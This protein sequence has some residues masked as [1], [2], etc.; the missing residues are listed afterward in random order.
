MNLGDTKLGRFESV[1]NEYSPN[2]LDRVPRCAS[3]SHSSFFSGCD[4]WYVHELSWLDLNGFPLRGVATL[5]IP[6][7]S[8]FMVE[9]KSAKLYFNSFRFFVVGSQVAL[10][11]LIIKDFSSLLGCPIGCKISDFRHNI[12]TPDCDSI[13]SCLDHDPIDNISYDIDSCRKYLKIDEA[14]QFCSLRVHTNLFLT[15][16]PVTSQPDFA[17][18]VIDYRGLSFDVKGLMKYLISYRHSRNFNEVCCDQVFKDLLNSYSP[19]HLV[20]ALFYTS[21]GGISITPAR[22]G[23][24]SVD[25]SVLSNI[26]GGNI[27]TI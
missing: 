20:L 17:T 16:C 21:R 23:G 12:G 19:E 22:Y 8:T 5:A 14:S 7:T 1:P 9:S 4:Y 6:S 25:S 27:I 26:L 13:G 24:T 15:H 10:E 3:I 2:V 18:A 11:E